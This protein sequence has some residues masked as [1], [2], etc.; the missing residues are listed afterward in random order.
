MK[1][2]KKKRKN[3]EEGKKTLKSLQTGRIFIIIGMC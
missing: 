1:S 3:E 2:K